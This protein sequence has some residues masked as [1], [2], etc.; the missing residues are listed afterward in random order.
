MV[1]DHEH[2]RLFRLANMVHP[3]TDRFQSVNEVQTFDVFRMLPVG[4]V[5]GGGAKNGDLYACR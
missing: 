4:N 1:T 5:V 2:V 3:D